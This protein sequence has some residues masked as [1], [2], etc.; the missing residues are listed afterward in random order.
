MFYTIFILR[1]ELIMD[2]C[3][4]CIHIP[5]NKNCNYKNLFKE[6]WSKCPN[7]I[8]FVNDCTNGKIIFKFNDLKE[9]I[10]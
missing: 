7:Y 6:D 8:K 1:K 9:I 2:K 4:N 3:K 10:K 5:C